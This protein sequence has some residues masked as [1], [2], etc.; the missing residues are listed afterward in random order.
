L[1]IGQQRKIPACLTEGRTRPQPAH[2]AVRQGNKGKQGGWGNTGADR[3]SEKT[4]VDKTPNDRFLHR[5]AKFLQSVADD[6]KHAT[7]EHSTQM[8]I[9][10]T[11]LN[12]FIKLSSFDSTE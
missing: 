2:P 7:I 11:P 5:S 6:V 4:C 1:T 12:K 8:P 9:F 3:G 10:A